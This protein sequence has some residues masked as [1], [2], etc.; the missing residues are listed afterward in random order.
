MAAPVVVAVPFLDR[1]RWHGGFSYLRTL[2]A[3]LRD[4]GSGRVAA[5][6]RAAPEDPAEDVAV[7]AGLAGR[8]PLVSAA[9]RRPAARTLA[10]RALGGGFPAAAA[11]YAAH[12][13]DVV[14]ETAEYHGWRFPLPVLAW[15][16]DL[17]HRLLPGMF[18]RAAW[19]RRELGFQLAL[20]AARQVLVSSDSARADLVRAYPFAAGRV[21]VAR[22]TAAPPP[23]ASPD[24]REVAARYGLPDRFLYLPNQ[25]WK[26]KNH[27][28]VIEA[29]AHLAREGVRPVVVCS[30]ATDDP[31]HPGLFGQLQAQA[32]GAGIADS[33]R[34]LGLIPYGDVLGLMRASIGLVNPSLFEGW[35]TTVEEAKAL[36]VPM[37]LSDLAVHRE[38]AGATG[39][40]FLPTS[41]AAAA[42]AIREAWA[43][44]PA[45]PRPAAEAAARE[46]L[47]GRRREFVLAFEAAVLAARGGA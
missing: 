28:V 23:G 31:R 26:H 34:F 25:L 38:Q 39:R 3:A 42:G 24:P 17:Q 12:G 8:P 4:H 30:G 5:V 16:T 13:V 37:L 7:L 10:W 14:F 41:A 36:G 32:A 21:A 19:W 47:E 1:R 20:R 2:L 44:W 43:A 40:F 22:F 27:G 45:G 11:A 35:S 15:V 29:L 9:F 33:V 18:S 46:A 6:V